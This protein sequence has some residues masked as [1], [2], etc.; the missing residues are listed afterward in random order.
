M[1]ESSIAYI[2]LLATLVFFAW[3][4]YRE[5]VG[6]E[7]D[8]DGFLSA[9]GS[10]NWIMIG[11]SLFASGMGVWILFGPSEVG[12]YGGFYDV[13]GYALSSATPFL[14]LAYLGPLIRK[15]TPEGVT[16]ADYVRQ[17]M[18]RTMQIYV[19]VISIIYMFTF[20]FAEYIAVGRAVEFLSGIDFLLPIVLVAIVTTFYTVMGGLP[21]SIK[22]DKIQSFFILWLIV[23]VILLILSEGFGNIFDDA[24]AHTPED[25][26][27]DWYHGSISDYSTFE[28]GLALVLAITA[29]E[30]FSQG[31]WQRTWASEDNEAL[32][33]GA[34]LASGLCFIAVL[35]FGFLGTVAAGR[36]ALSDPSIAFFELIKDYNELVL[37]MFLVLG[38]ALVCSSIDTLQNAVVAVVSRD[39]TD[40]KLDIVQAKYVVV[41]IAPIAIFLAWFFADE[42]LSVFRIFL[43]ADLFAAATVLPIFL[44]LSD[45]VTANGG[46]VGAIFGLIS[47]VIYGAYTS[48]LQTGLDYLTNPVNEYGLAN[49]YVFLSALIG[50]ALMTIIVS[51]IENSQ[52]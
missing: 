1:I 19:G 8:N 22:T 3:L 27:W 14:L 45:R 38:V 43:V 39:L 36:G 2:L 23:C 49:L 12:Y 6:K 31:N 35:L 26:E 20:M 10:Q 34:F 47:V 13:M 42:S 52:S 29:A 30:M 7:L 33:K 5:S 32:R 21:V 48:D 17:R 41:G 46:L 40:S 9:R 16:L 15:L 28:A 18:G 37:A 44:S 25:I 4:G 51:E 24:N 11:L 50:S